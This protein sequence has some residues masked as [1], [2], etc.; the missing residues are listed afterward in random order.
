MCPGRSISSL[1]PEVKEARIDFSI[2]NGASYRPIVE[3]TENTGSYPW[4]VPPVVSGL[5]LVRVSSADGTAADAESLSVEFKIKMSSVQAGSSTS[6]LII[7]TTVPDIETASTWS[8]EAAFVPDEDRKVMALQLNAASTD[9]AASSSFFDNWHTI[10][11]AENYGA[12][13][14]SVWLDGR[15]M[16]Q[17]VPLVQG[18]WTGASPLVE[19]RAAGLSGDRI[20]D[21]KARYKDLT[22]KPEVQGE[23]VSQLLARDSFEG[24]AEG[25][26]P[27]QGGWL[28]NGKTDGIYE[29]QN[30]GADQA[31]FADSLSAG[32]CNDN[33][34]IE[35]AGTTK[36]QEG[37]IGIFQ[38]H[39]VIYAGKNDKGIEEVYSTHGDKEH[40]GK[41]YRK[42]KLSDWT[43]WLGDDVIWYR[44]NTTEKKD[45]A[46][47]KN[48]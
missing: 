24:Y 46:T 4:L 9:A 5:C 22:L 20:E 8:V 29:Y 37:D 19:I 48:K 31:T 25:R 12:K 6:G 47:E 18:A 30:V 43:T 41:G 23:E 26:F 33:R 15:P 44:Y 32:K 3:R 7:R 39:M 45:N 21:F 1:G 10:R 13:A 38:G 16:L 11:L 27:S 42:D 14:A 2:D 28:L 40:E 36:L 35:S 34:F 17:M